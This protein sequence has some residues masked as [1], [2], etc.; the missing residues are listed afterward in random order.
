MTLPNMGGWVN[1]NGTQVVESD[2]FQLI[3]TSSLA[4]F[5]LDIAVGVATPPHYVGMQ[6]FSF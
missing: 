3:S 1:G 6:F 4:G 2:S 5:T